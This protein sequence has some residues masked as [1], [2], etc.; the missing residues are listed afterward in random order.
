MN[1]RMVVYVASSFWEKTLA[2]LA[3]SEREIGGAKI[4]GGVV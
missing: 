4:A 2:G 3:L 1:G